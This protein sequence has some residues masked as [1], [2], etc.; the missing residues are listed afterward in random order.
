M[1]S[2]MGSVPL[3]FYP[4]MDYFFRFPEVFSAFLSM[5]AKQIANSR[6]HV[7]TLASM[8]V[9]G[10]QPRHGATGVR[11]F[12]LDLSEPKPRDQLPKPEALKDFNCRRHNDTYCRGTPGGPRD[13]SLDTISIR[14]SVVHLIF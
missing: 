13:H 1:Q 6:K 5:G 3:N 7:L 14:V 10:Q 9:P 12:A 2:R 11:Y 4:K 8:R